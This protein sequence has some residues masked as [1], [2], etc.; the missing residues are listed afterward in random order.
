MAV[1]VPLRSD[2]D[3]A[4]LRALAKRSR[5]QI[6]P[7]AFWLWRRSMMGQPGPRQLRSAGSRCRSCATGW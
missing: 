6:R 5:I 7:G 3:A 2:F 1:A 4:G